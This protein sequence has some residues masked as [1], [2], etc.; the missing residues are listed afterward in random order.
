[1][2]RKLFLTIV[3]AIA[4][5]ISLSG[6]IAGCGQGASTTT[7]TVARL[8]TVMMYA[9]G[10]HNLEVSMFNNINQMELTGS[11]GQVAMVAETDW[12]RFS[13]S[14]ESLTTTG[15]GI[16]R[17]YILK[18]GDMAKI[19][20]QLVM[21][22]PE[23]DTGTAEALQSFVRWAIQNY[24]A[25]HYMLVV[26]SHGGGWRNSSINSVTGHGSGQDYTTD[27]TKR[28]LITI[29]QF[30]AIMPAIITDAGKKL[31]ILAFDACMN[32]GIEMAYTMKDYFDYMVASEENVPGYGFPLDTLTAD[33]VAT[34]TMTS[35]AFAKA[36]V[37]RYYDFY[38]STVGSDQSTLA[39]YDL[40]KVT[41]LADEVKKLK[42]LYDTGTKEALLRSIIETQSDD[43]NYLVQ[44]YYYVSLRD[45]WHMADKIIAGSTGVDYAAITIECSAVKSAVEQ[46][47]ILSKYTDPL[48]VP[49][50]KYALANSHGVS[51]Y[52]ST[53]S[54]EAYDTSYDNLDFSTYTGWGAFLYNK[55]Q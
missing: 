15:E 41:V 39:A 35:E 48:P 44:R 28:R 40:S 11:T 47:V 31:D 51:I 12:Y 14:A 38:S 1:M 23:I 32:G 43:Q 55:F 22:L 53:S 2:R 27:P 29:P 3:M 13:G 8:W 5:M 34:P 49:S 18:D 33:L 21:S 7:T 4:A 26:S 10:D 45:L 30:K 42:D 54:T 37:N 17:W 6:L 16:G 24:P 36:I 19:K 52:F 9:A 20:S 50:N 46:M 25:S